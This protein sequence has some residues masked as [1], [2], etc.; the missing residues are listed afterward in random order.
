[1]THVFL[2]THFPSLVTWLN[3]VTKNQEIFGGMAMMIT[4]INKILLVFIRKRHTSV[5][6]QTLL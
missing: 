2:K 6:A 4:T 5:R 3:P 1:M